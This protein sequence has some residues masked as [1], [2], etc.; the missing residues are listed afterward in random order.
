MAAFPAV[1]GLTFPAYQRAPL[2]EPPE[3]GRWPLIVFS[4][5]VGCSRLMY[6]QIC[7][8]LASRGFVV[9]AVEHRDGTGPSAIVIGEDGKER[10]VEFLRWNKLESVSFPSSSGRTTET[11]ADGCRWPDLPPDQQPE[12]DTTLRHDQLKIRLIELQAT[13]DALKQ[14]DTG[15]IGTKGRLQASRTYD[16]T[17]WANK[18]QTGDGRIGLAGHSFGGTA[19][20]AAADDERFS[21]SN[22]IIMDPAIQRE[23]Q[24]SSSKFQFVQPHKA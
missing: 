10:P 17:Q 14:I 2:E 15:E 8:E 4:H 24:V 20:L 1:H 9:A 13:I 11:C 19:V 16:W 6:T 7:G 21:P 5:G 12:N 22:L 23:F 18:L 3:G